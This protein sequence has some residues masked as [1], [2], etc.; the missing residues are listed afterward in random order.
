MVKRYFELPSDTRQLG[1]FR[2]QLQ[3]LLKEAGLDEKSAGEVLLAIQETLTNI[4]RHSYR[5]TSGKIQINFQEDSGKV[6]ISIRDFGKKFDITQVP[7]PKL[8]R[9]EPGGLGIY[10]IKNTMDEVRYDSSCQDG[11]LLHLVKY[12]SRSHS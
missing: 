9:E 10:L 2:H 1:D 12:K 6:T 4:I 7:D 3:S 5:D 8:P 11:N